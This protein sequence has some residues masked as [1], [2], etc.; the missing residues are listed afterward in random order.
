[1]PIASRRNPRLFSGE[2]WPAKGLLSSA[3]QTSAWIGLYSALSLAVH[4]RT[5]EIAI[6]MAMGSRRRGVVAMIMREAALASYLPAY[7]ASRID[8]MAGLRR[9]E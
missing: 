6:R 8:P 5:R 1:V 3:G 9:D 7:G 4:R 2:V